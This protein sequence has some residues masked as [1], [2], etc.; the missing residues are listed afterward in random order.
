MIKHLKNIPSFHLLQEHVSL[1]LTVIQLSIIIFVFI[2]PINAQSKPIIGDYSMFTESKYKGSIYIGSHIIADSVVKHLSELKANTYLWAIEQPNAWADLANFLPKAN[3]AGISV[4]VYLIPPSESSSG[5]PPYYIDYISWTNAIAKLSLRYS[6]LIGYVI[7]DF[8]YNTNMYQ[9]GSLF[10]S[11]YITSMVNTGKAI[12]P[13][14]KFYPLLYSW[15]FN[16][17]ASASYDTLFV[18]NLSSL[19]DGAVVA[20][21]NEH[22]YASS[23]SV[24]IINTIS[25]LNDQ[26]F[27]LTVTYP[28]S[29][30]STKGD[31]GYAT[32]T[33]DITN[34]SDI[35]IEIDYNTLNYLND[36]T[37]HVLELRANNK[38][39]WKKGFGSYGYFGDTVISLTSA[40]TGVDICSLQL[41]IYNST[42]VYNYPA[43]ANYIVKNV[44]GLNYSYSAWKS[45]VQG[46]YS[47][48]IRKGNNQYHLPLIIMP[49]ADSTQY[50]KRYSDPATPA[51]ITN[52]ISYA[53]NFA[54]NKIEGIIIYDLNL[55]GG[56]TFNLVKKVFSNISVKP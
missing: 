2:L 52:R 24:D 47:V 42:M 36:S 19:I 26:Y 13:K 9:P 25:F 55:L 20:F 53:G 45:K 49:S 5:F 38:V 41:G 1:F 17:S 27:V 21:P 11:A 14:L 10:S 31:Y 23:D 12:N 34:H 54:P 3:R 28:P 22:E 37:Y 50:A 48:R 43:Y 15:T 30:I 44:T 16:N 6:N 7:D 56:A 32:Q 29:H 35:S 51:N 33:C 18:D 46:A 4:W 8:W 39:V 40:L